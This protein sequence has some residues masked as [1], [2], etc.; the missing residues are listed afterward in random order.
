[1]ERR[2]IN[3]KNDQIPFDARQKILSNKRKRMNNSLLPN[4]QFSTKE[5]I[6]EPRKTITN[7]YAKRNR[8]VGNNKS[9][10]NHLDSKNIGFVCV[11]NGQRTIKPKVTM[12]N[13]Q[14][15]IA[16]RNDLVNLNKKSSNLPSKTFFPSQKTSVEQSKFNN[17]SHIYENHIKTPQKCLTELKRTSDKNHLNRN[18]TLKSNNIY[19]KPNSKFEQIDNYQKNISDIEYKQFKANNMKSFGKHSEPLKNWKFVVSN[20]HN[21]DQLNSQK[22][23]KPKVT[24]KDSQLRI[25]VTNDYVNLNNKSTNLPTKT[26][27]SIPNYSNV[28]QISYHSSN[29]NAQLPNHMYQE[30]FYKSTEMTRLSRDVRFRPYQNKLKSVLK[31]ASSSEGLYDDLRQSINSYKTQASVSICC[32]PLEGT[33]IIVSNLHPDVS[34]D[35]VLELFCVLGP[36]KEVTKLG[37]GKMKVIFVRNLDAVASFVKYDGRELD[38]QPMQLELIKRKED[39]LSKARYSWMS[40][41]GVRSNLSGANS[42]DLELD[43]LQKALFK[44]GSN[45][46]LNFRPVSFVVEV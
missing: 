31:A 14:L 36:I 32:S 2:F 27:S 35:D 3:L 44:T 19:Q 17:S 8:I 29:Q 46:R 38:G 43:I 7:E 12:K 1:M 4:P 37:F 23:V 10:K 42:L 11:T 16:V 34:R 30:S 18:I 41:I 21:D 5:K 6:S 20:H 28:H 45:T 9:E 39:S 40:D 24:M 13:S 25:A 15:M 33:K 26:F 22:T